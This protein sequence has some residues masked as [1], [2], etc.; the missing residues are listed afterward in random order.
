MRKKTYN[1]HSMY[2]DIAMLEENLT[3][4]IKIKKSLRHPWW[5]SGPPAGKMDSVLDPGRSHMPP[6]C[7]ARALEPV[8]SNKRKH[9]HEK[10]EHRN[11]V[12]LLAATGDGLQ[13]AVRTQHS[14]QCSSF[15]LLCL[16]LLHR[17]LPELAQTHVNRVGDAIQPSHLSSP[18]PPA[19]NLFQHQGLFQWVSSLHRM[20][21]VLEF[22]LQHQSF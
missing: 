13:A 2:T 9:C 21:K 4:V 22:Q 12:T 16:T 14:H 20:A 8:S 7:W 6:D 19:F 1:R 11:S 18:S 3:V 15:A 10:P 5:L 17:Q